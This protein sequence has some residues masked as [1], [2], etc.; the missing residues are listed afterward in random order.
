MPAP[1]TKQLFELAV[2]HFCVLQ[3]S[4]EEGLGRFAAWF[5]AYYGTDG[6]N[7]RPDEIHYHPAR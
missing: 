6:S 7:L 1:G 3:V 5:Y 2:E 4:L